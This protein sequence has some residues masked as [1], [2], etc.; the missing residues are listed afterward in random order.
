MNSYRE[1]KVWQRAIDLV[2]ACYE[3]TRKF[4]DDERYGLTSQLRRAAVSV[5]ANI[6]EGHGRGTKKAFL[7]FQWIA[8]GSLTELETHFII[9]GKLGYVSREAGRPVYDQ[10][11][12]I[13]RMLSSLRRSLKRAAYRSF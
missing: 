10:M 6:A 3:L 2:V 1:L 13:G 9:A 5:A 11:Q 7:N 8:N 12:E 4:P